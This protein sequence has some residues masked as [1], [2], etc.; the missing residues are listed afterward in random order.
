MMVRRVLGWLDT[1]LLG[2]AGLFLAGY[3]T[4]VVLQVFFRYVLEYAL[5]WTEEVGVYLFVW[6]AFMA[7]AVVVGKNDHFSIS[8][9]SEWLGRTSERSLQVAITLLCLSFTVI[10]MW[11]GTAWSWRMLGSFSP[12]LQ[13]PQGAI[14]AIIPLSGAYMAVHLVVRLWSLLDHRR[15]WTTDAEPRG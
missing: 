15:P 12:V 13:L 3:L 1:L 11:M 5:P 4:T 10:M 8:L 9:M 7:A 2:M 14:Y 6:S